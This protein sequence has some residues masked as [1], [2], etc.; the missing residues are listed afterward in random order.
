MSIG[1]DPFVD[2]AAKR[3]PGSP[4]HSRIALHF[5]AVCC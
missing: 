4:E 2:F 1:I 5:L 3:V